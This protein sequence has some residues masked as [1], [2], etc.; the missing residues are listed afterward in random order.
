ME[1]TKTDSFPSQSVRY[2]GLCTHT[3]SIKNEARRQR[4]KLLDLISK[5]VVVSRDVQVNEASEWDWN[6]LTEVIIKVGESS[7]VAATT[8]TRSIPTSIPARSIPTNS[9]TN[10][11]EDEPQHPR[12]RSLQ[13][14]Y[15]KTDEVHLVCLLTDAKNISFEEAM[16]DEKW[17]TAMDEEIEAIDRNNTWELTNLPKGSQPIGVK[18]V[19]KKKM[20]AQGEIERYKTRLVAKGY[21]QKASTDRNWCGDID[22]RKST[23]GYVFFMGDIAF[24]WLSKKQTIVTLS[25]CEAKYLAASWCV[26]HAIWL[27]NLLSKMMLK[28][29]AGTVIHVENKSS[30]ELA[31]NPVNHERSKHIDVHFHFI[32]DH[33]KEGNVELVHVASQ[34]QVADI[35]TKSL[36][37]VLLNKCKKMINMMDG[38][39]I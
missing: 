10:D 23:S 4:Q 35:F 24:T 21:K 18:W 27:R 28:Q 13:D 26:C 38:R 31:K 39:S 25:T 11:D 5:K 32:R 14:L 9:E 20:N 34:D 17:P 3:G 33:V 2:C 36:P 37:K 22:D 19:F 30:I 12:M 7:V 8:T 6:N 29:A 15:D 16:R 1:R